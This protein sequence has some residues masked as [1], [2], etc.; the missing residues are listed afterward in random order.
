MYA[1]RVGVSLNTNTIL[2]YKCKNLNFNIKYNIQSKS[3]EYCILGTTFCNI[4]WY[5]DINSH[6]NILDTYI[7]EVWPA[8]FDNLVHK[9]DGHWSE[10][11]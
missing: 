5:T 4:K 10:N 8:Y 7:S 9:P 1:H 11:K 3:I 6:P 2:V